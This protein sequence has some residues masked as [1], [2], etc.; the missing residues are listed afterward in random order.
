MINDTDD[1][2][3]DLKILAFSS[4]EDFKKKFWASYKTYLQQFNA[5]L[6]RF[7]AQGEF[8]EIQQI[9]SVPAGQKAHLGIGFTDAEQAKLREISNAAQS[10]LGK[11]KDIGPQRGNSQED[12]GSVAK[13]CLKFHIVATQLTRR[14][15][16]RETIRINDE[17]DVQD[18]LHALLKVDFDDVRTEEW[19]PSYAGG[20]ARMDFL[21]KREQTVIETKKTRA[22]ISERELGEQ[23]VVDIEKYQG[24]ADCK[25]LVCFVYDPNHLLANPRGLEVDLEKLGKEI[26]VRVFVRPSGE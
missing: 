17:Y 14:H 12:I 1:I 2:I 25:T 3:T 19:T 18:L 11:L 16:N 26:T 8:L 24:H 5:V 15:A 23:L 13:L 6:G 7:H 22:G 21:L 10:L 20:A 4:R 9:A